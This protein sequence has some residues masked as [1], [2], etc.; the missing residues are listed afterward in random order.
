MPFPELL[1]TGTGVKVY[2]I[3][4]DLY[5]VLILA[6]LAWMLVRR[7]AAK[8]YRLSFDL[9]RNIDAVIVVGLTAG[10]MVATLLV[11]AFYVASGGQGPEAAVPVGGLLADA[12][13]GMG[14]SRRRGGSPPRHFLV[15]APGHHPWALAFTS[16]L[17]S[18]FT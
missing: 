11:H 16:P 14:I 15:G 12:F 7:W 3:Y 1:L 18:T 8:P 13:T 4:L 5:A 9:T 6:I 17:P 2:S 10:L